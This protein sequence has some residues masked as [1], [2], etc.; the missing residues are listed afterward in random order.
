[1]PGGAA[2][3]VDVLLCTFRRPGVRDT[4]NSL[5]AQALPAGVHL[6]VIVADN[7][8]TAS[9]RPLIEE[10]AGAFAHPLIYLHAPARNISIA[11]N[12]CL[13]QATGDFVAFLDDDEIAPPSWIAELLAA[14]AGG[15]DG[16]IAPVRAL[17][18]KDAPGWMVAGDYHSNRPVVTKAGVETG[19]TCNALLRWRGQDWADLR[20]DLS[21][22]QSGGEDTA[23]FFAVHGRGARLVATQTAQLTEAV[24]PAR[25][26]FGWLWQRQFR[27]GQSHVS[28]A[29][30][31]AGRARLAGLAAL[32]AAVCAGM[33]PLAALRGRGRFWALRGALHL[34]VIAGALALPQARI[35]GKG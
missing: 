33:V 10:M 31:A 16:V 32:K 1:M 21:R 17:Y 12:A 18:P 29:T 7:D 23:F 24:A 11:R 3:Q 2:L 8:D 28:G 9:A 6:R 34:G 4:L 13:A 25:L 19:H 15:A 26:R 35:Y 14:A 20:F 30:G 5:N 27:A 22:G